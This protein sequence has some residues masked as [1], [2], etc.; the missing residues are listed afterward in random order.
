MILDVMIRTKDL[1]QQLYKLVGLTEDEVAYIVS[2]GGVGED[3]VF[4]DTF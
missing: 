2:V 4:R 3:G 1:D